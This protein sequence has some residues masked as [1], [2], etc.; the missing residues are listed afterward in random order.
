MK[1]IQDDKEAMKAMYERVLVSGLRDNK[2]KMY[3]LSASLKGQSYD[4][5]RMMAFSP[6]WL[7]N[8]LSGCTYL[9]NAICNSFKDNF[10]TSAFVKPEIYG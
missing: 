8:Q 2:L 10:M 7:E 1:T 3:F 4:M 9:T 5:G 6:G